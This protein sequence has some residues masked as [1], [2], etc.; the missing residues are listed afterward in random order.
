MEVSS[1]ENSESSLVRSPKRP[2]LLK[3]WHRYGESSTRL[4]SSETLPIV[5]LHRFPIFN[6]RPTAS[7]FPLKQQ[8]FLLDTLFATIRRS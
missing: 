1:G 5:P 8:K 2:F 3:A 6:R 7:K 4:C